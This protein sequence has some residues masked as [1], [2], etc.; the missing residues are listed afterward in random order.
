MPSLILSKEA[1]G[2]IVSATEV[3]PVAALPESP[4]IIG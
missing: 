3:L 4:T 2:T 1:L